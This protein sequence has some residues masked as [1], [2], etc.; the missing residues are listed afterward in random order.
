MGYTIKSYVGHLPQSLLVTTDSDRI[1]FEQPLNERV[2][3]LLRLEFLF[4]QYRHHRAGDT[5]WNHRAALHT[6]LD[7]LSVLGRNDLK[8]DL[9]KELSDQAH[10]LARLAEHDGVDRARLDAVLKE[11][12]TACTNLRNSTTHYPTAILRD[13][14]LLSAV[15]NR[16]AIP[17]GTCAFDLPSYHRWLSLPHERITADLDYWFGQL[18]ALDSAIQTYLRLLRESTESTEHVTEHGI[19]LYSPP[20]RYHLIRVLV[21]SQLNVFPEISATRHRFS[22]RFIRLGD[23]H[24]HNTQEAEPVPFRMQCCALAS[25]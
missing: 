23:T 12:D 7:V 3:S 6:L 17:G 1:V 19:F 5:V 2:R 9:L 8:T 18:S 4:S 10:A 20:A 24:K 21:S 16:F 11:L 22:V 14:D 15:S 25:I 13:S